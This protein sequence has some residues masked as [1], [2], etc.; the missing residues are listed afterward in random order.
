MFKKVNLEKGMYQDAAEKGLTIAQI[1]EQLDPSGNHPDSNL[2]A[3]ERQLA[4]RGLVIQGPKSISLDQFY[5]PDNRILFPEFINREIQAG[6]IM[7]RIQLQV[8][9][10]IATTTEIDSGVYDAA[11]LD[12]GQDFHMKPIGEGAKFPKIT[13]TTTKKPVTLRK[14]GLKLRETYE[15]RRRIKANLFAVILRLIGQYLMLDM[16]DDAVDVEIN[17]NSGNSNAASTPAVGTAISYDKLIDFFFAFDPYEANLLAAPIAG[18][19]AIL[20]LSEFKDPLVGWDFQKTGN[21]VTP[22]GMV[23]RKHNTTALTDKLLGIDKR[24]S[25]EQ[26]TER[27][28]YL[29]ETDKLIDGQ[30]NEIAISLVT[31]F[32]KIIADSAQV[33]DYS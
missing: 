23:M 21:L 3:F 29:T 28:S 6:M 9:D 8:A 25:L 20:K 31:G 15:H 16:V 1:L 14:H 27:G 22:M 26:V 33:W 24:F 32:S 11:L 7:S 12:V 13:I 17:G 10:L 4:A 5:D 30:W 18:L 2:D 19:K